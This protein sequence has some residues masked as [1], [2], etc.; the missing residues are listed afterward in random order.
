MAISDFGMS[1]ARRAAL[2]ARGAREIITDR[3]G[4]SDVAEKG[5]HD[6]VTAT[7]RAVQRLLFAELAAE[8]PDFALFG[9][10]GTHSVRRLGRTRV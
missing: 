6:F 1:V 5:A 7:D 4:A 3:R 8:F 2:A 10:E 9:E